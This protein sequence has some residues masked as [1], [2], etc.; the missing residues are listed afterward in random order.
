MRPWSVDIVLFP[1]P[2]QFLT[3]VILVIS[4]LIFSVPWLLAAASISYTDV[5]PHHSLGRPAGAISDVISA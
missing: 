3:A 2:R 5:Q 1:V 4:Y